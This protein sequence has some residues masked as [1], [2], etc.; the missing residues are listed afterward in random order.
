[1]SPTSGQLDRIDRAVIAG[2]AAVLLLPIGLV[3]ASLTVVLT[4]AVQDALTREPLCSAGMSIA[5]TSRGDLA[6][7]STTRSLPRGWTSLSKGD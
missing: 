2:A 4:N 1:M 3:A 5:V 7:L 6:C